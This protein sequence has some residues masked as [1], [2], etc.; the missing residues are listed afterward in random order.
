MKVECLKYVENAEMSEN[1]LDIP[2]TWRSP[3]GKRKFA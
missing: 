2:G 1:N 3:R